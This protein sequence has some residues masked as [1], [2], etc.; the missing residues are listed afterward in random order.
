MRVL[1]SALTFLMSVSAIAQTP[2]LQVGEAKNKKSSIALTLPS[3]AP[4]S[5]G[6]AL[7]I[8]QQT[9]QSDLEFTDQ[10]R[11]LA[12]A[13][14]PK[15]QII[16]KSD[17]A[18]PEWAK[19][20][21]DFVSYGSF[22]QEG[23]HITYEFHFMGVG[24]T[25]EVLGKR[26]TAE[27]S[28]LKPLAHSIANDIVNAI[29]GKKGIFTSR[30]AFICDKSGKKEIYTSAYDGSD[31]RQ[32]TRLKSLAMSPAW[33]PDGK[34]IGFS[35]YNRH[36]DNTKNIDLFEYDFVSGKLTLLSNRK[37]INSGINSGINLGTK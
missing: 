22:T 25:Q 23:A 30:I 2:Y 27:A 33:S 15:K 16:N 32:V 19:A 11:I 21:A 29:T 14:F 10:F 18:F 34:R 3:A 4:A 31:V 37:G 7:S 1:L 13:G 35:V 5:A 20:G 12:E 28:D 26:Y 24:S 36:S 8:I 17:L 6:A 9:V